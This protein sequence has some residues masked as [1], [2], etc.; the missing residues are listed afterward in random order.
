MSLRAL[1]VVLAMAAAA[2][3]VLW[4]QQASVSDA[5]GQL[6]ATEPAKL[7]VPTLGGASAGTVAGAA[8]PSSGAAPSAPIPSGTFPSRATGPAGTGSV[9]VHV[10]GAVK[11]PGVVSLPAGSRVFQAIAAAG[12][13][14]PGAQLSA[15]NLAAIAADGTQI[16]VPTVQQAANAAANAPVGTAAGSDAG[17]GTTK[18]AGPAAGPININTA[19]ADQLDGL[20][21]VGPV[22]AGRIVAWRTDHG[23]FSSVDA[24]DA[25]SG[26]G[27]KMLATLRPLVTVQ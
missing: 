3:G 18:A 27:P 10:V 2:V 4:L 20:P 12:G 9:L 17:A 23:P 25:V 19:T 22:L 11:H 16:L 21:G 7:A 6:A 1:V 5:S 15:I 13:A 26:I 24:L 14:V 8:A